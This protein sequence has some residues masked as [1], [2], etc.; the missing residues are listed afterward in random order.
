MLN[1]RLISRLLARSVREESDQALA[2]R[3]WRAARGAERL[4]TT[5]VHVRKIL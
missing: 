1:V 5:H 3:L 4:D 2:A